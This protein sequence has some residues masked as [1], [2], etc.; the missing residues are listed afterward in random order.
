M[1]DITVNK[2]SLVTGG[3]GEFDP[4]CCSKL[5]ITCFTGWSVWQAWG[6]SSASLKDRLQHQ[7]EQKAISDKGL[8]PS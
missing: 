8:K 7:E 6:L 3:G 5:P 1:K 2:L 4:N